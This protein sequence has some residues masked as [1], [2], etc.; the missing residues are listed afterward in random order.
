MNWQRWQKLL[1]LEASLLF[2]VTGLLGKLCPMAWH[3][4]FQCCEQPCPHW[5]HHSLAYDCAKT[6][7]NPYPNL[8]QA[9]LSFK[10]AQVTV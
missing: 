10:G 1:I 9:L 6:N 3:E 2:W 4:G 7:H 8:P 5:G